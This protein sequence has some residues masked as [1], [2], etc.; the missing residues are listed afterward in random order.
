[1]WKNSITGG[2]VV[3]LKILPSIEYVKML[4]L[5]ETIRLTLRTCIYK[6]G[7]NNLGGYMYSTNN[8][9]HDIYLNSSVQNRK[10]SMRNHW[11]AA[12]F[13]NIAIFRVFCYYISLGWMIK[14][15]TEINSPMKDSS[16]WIFPLSSTSMCCVHKFSINP[17]KVLSGKTREGSNNT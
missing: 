17:F 16:I 13:L 5:D 9:V 2:G 3:R 7:Y 12:E 4:N 15:G 8:T 10:T 11:G 6:N 14:T 1:M